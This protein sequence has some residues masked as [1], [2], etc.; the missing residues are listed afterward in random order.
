M[1]VW[2]VNSEPTKLLSLSGLKIN[3]SVNMRLTKYF[4]LIIL[5]SVSNLLFARAPVFAE[6]DYFNHPPRVI[7][8]CCAFGTDLR[9]SIIPFA[10]LNHL[11]SAELLGTHRYLGDKEEKN[12]ILYS[13]RGGF[14]DLGH[15]RDYVDW[16]A[17][18]YNLEKRSQREG[19]MHINLAFEAGEKFLIIKIPASEKE[20]DLI[21]LAGRIAYDLSIWHE[22]T[23][24]F[25]ASSV[26]L[27]SEKF[28]SF[29]LEDAYSNVL[30][31][32]IAEEAIKS[33][34]PYET[35]V[36]EIIK[37]TL[38]DLEAVS[39]KE[40]TIQAYEAVRDIWWTRKKPLPCNK[41]MIQR[42]IGVYPSVSPMIVPGWESKTKGSLTLAIAETTNGGI[43]L[44]EFYTLG[45]NTNC[46]IPVKK[47][48]PGRIDKMLTQKD[49]PGVLDYIAADMQ[50]K[51][52]HVKR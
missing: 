4:L 39:S 17:Y 7:R 21:N 19:E 1:T 32:K 6:K 15:L 35:A 46:H 45:F 52:F 20:E 29:S 37:N 44:S 8:V 36:T 42:N 11:T 34:L 26:P 22:I 16:T 40:E 49:F 38:N 30:G 33:N 23:S 43:P 3:Q 31:T 13:R 51:N 14:I 2:D 5:C 24:W 18:I 48:F 25:G 27:I 41:I 12:G 10:K 47:I 50:K 28:S 9:I